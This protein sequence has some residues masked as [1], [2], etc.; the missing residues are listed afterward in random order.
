VSARHA[1]RRRSPVYAD[2]WDAGR[3]L[4]A[5]LAAAG[6]EHAVVVGLMRGG[7]PVA[8]EVAARLGAPLDA[9]VVRKVGHPLQGEF[10]IGAVSA[11]G[12]IQLAPSTGHDSVERLWD[13]FRTAVE[14][15]RRMEGRLHEDLPSIDLAGRPCILVDDGL[16]TGATMRVAVR[17]AR[18]RGASR[19]V[20]AVPVGA[21]ESLAELEEE[22]D[23][24]VCPWTPEP[25]GAVG[26]WYQ[27]F[28]P[29]PEGEVIALLR[30]SRAAAAANGAPAA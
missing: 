26:L 23:E 27:D 25:F 13:G 29:V 30:A 21:R 18:S 20:V 16:A 9:L 17:S 1:A 10:A 8:A 3:R 19:V 2:R 28:A 4:G 5:I 12:L 11:D 24:V 15:A 7:V 6:R 22:A 14:E